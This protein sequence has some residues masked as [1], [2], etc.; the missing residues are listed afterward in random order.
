MVEPSYLGLLVFFY[1][2]FSSYMFISLIV[3]CT[4]S[5]SSLS[6]LCLILFIMFLTGISP[7]IA[8]SVIYAA[9]VILNWWSLF[10]KW[11]SKSFKL[12]W[13]D[14]SFLRVSV[15]HIIF[16]YFY[17]FYCLSDEFVLFLL[18]ISL[19]SRQWPTDLR[20]YFGYEIRMFIVLVIKKFISFQF[21]FIYTVKIFI[22]ISLMS[23]QTRINTIHPFSFKLL[24]ELWNSHTLT[25]RQ[26]ILENSFIG[27]R[28]IHIYYF[29]LPFFLVIFILTFVP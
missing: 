18:D 11:K 10:S 13:L 14:Y 27:N 5:N 12:Q 7:S 29:T 16:Y 3:L 26:S 1:A 9:F 17:Y 22:T 4:N 23:K 28:L 15:V 19:N 25:I 21:D 20:N 8:M 24:T 6:S 2:L